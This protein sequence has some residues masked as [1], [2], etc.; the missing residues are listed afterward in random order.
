MQIT[1]NRWIGKTCPEGWKKYTNRTVSGHPRYLRWS[2]LLAAVLLCIS[3]AGGETLGKEEDDPYHTGPVGDDPA[4][5][6]AKAVLCFDDKF[7]Y[8]TCEESYRLTQSG[9]LNVPPDYTDVYCNGPCLQETYLVLNCI[10]G[11]L[12]HFVF[13]N[14]ATIQDIRDTLQAGC[15]HTSERGKFNVS[16]HIEAQKNSA[17]KALKPVL[18]GLGLVVVAMG[19]LLML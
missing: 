15:S 16:E 9:N 10:E 13:Y 14:K 4:Q 5:I 3:V 19:H 18:L 7:I 17:H 2:W 11:I 6:V 12:T 1:L 8:S